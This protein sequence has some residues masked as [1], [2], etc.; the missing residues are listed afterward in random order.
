MSLAVAC[1]LHYVRPMIATH[2]ETA[3]R[4]VKRQARY[5]WELDHQV[6]DA[7]FTARSAAHMQQQLREQ[8]YDD[9]RYTKLPKYRQ[10]ALEAYFRGVA[11]AVAR[12]GGAKPITIPPPAVAKEKPRAR[13]SERPKRNT[14][15]APAVTVNNPK[16]PVVDELPPWVQHLPAGVGA[17]HAP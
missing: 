8:V 4:Q 15:P 10:I 7:V 1:G 5:E 9:P 13:P 2:L 12:L 16:A 17:V 3:S 6:L 11:D 14:T